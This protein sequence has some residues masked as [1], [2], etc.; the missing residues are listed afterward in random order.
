[1]RAKGLR[2]AAL[3]VALVLAVWPAGS[4]RTLAAGYPDRP[5]KLLVGFGAGGG[6]DIVARILAS[7]CPTASANRSSSRTAPGRVAWSQR[8]TWRSRRPTATHS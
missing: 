4:V 5:I 1:M 2:R 7:K 6:T 8:Q 3:A